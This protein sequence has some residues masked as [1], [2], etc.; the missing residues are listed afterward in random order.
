MK[1]KR[2]LLWLGANLCRLLLSVTFVFSGVVKLIDPR[3]TQ[4][5]IEDYA[6]AFNVYTF[7]PRGGELLLA[8]GLALL[9]FFIG[10]NLFFGI[11]RRGTTRMALVLLLILT[12]LT[13]YL[14]LTN[15]VAD[16][17][18]FGD[19]VRLTN[20][21]T[22]AKNVVLLMAT[23]VAMVNYRRL[24]RFITERN[25]WVVSL[26][27]AVFAIFLA[28]YSI[29]YLPVI[30]FRPYCIGTNLP[31]AIEDDFSGH[32]PEPRYLD[33]MI[34]T[35]EGED[36]TM[37]WLGQPGY[38]FLLVAPWLEIADDGSTDQVNAIYD[39]CLQQGYPFL[40]L[41]ASMEESIKRWK[42]LTGAEYDFAQADGTLLKTIIR[43]SPGLIL[44][45][46][47][48]IYNKWSCNSL[49]DETLLTAPLDETKLGQMQRKSRV[50][51]A[52]H[53]L[54][55]F[56]LPLLIWTLIDRVWIG[57]KLYRWHKMRKEG[58]DARK[59]EKDK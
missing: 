8:V 58:R 35:T 30:D 51:S 29:H 14:A 22:F 56:V 10:F 6:V 49:P 23:I 47:G 46:D 54:L 42:D 33:F 52:Y 24:T 5:R 3:G 32:N 21:Q 12:P 53:L 37:Q 45:R 7:L 19:I 36:I 31:K 15:A 1:R 4:Y 16:C 48:V 39:Y 9:E 20:W 41:T 17:G 26:Y 34:Q 44:F 43:S 11:R 13:L 38:K 28:M 59:K 25:Q 27:A 18:C 40:A 2:R 55:W 50:R 57:S